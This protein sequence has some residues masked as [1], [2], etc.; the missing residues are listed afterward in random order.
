MWYIHFYLR[1][2]TTDVIIE[3]KCYLLQLKEVK[4][5]RSVAALFQSIK[6]LKYSMHLVLLN[7]VTMTNQAAE[8]DRKH[9]TCH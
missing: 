9:Y 3:R 2:P 4:L 6:G 8:R 1:I 7:T 5:L